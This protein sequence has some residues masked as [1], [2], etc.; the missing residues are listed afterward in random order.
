MAEKKKKKMEFRY[1]QL[2]P[3]SPI[4]ALLGEKWVQ[5]YGDRTADRLHFHNYMELGYCYYGAGDV[6][7][8]DDTYRF[9]GQQ[10]TVIPSNFPHT[11]NSDPGNIS[12]WEYLFV[13]VEVVLDGIFPDNALRKERALQRLYEKPWFLEE[14]EYPKEAAKIKEILNIMRKGDEFYLE[15]A[16]ALL[17][18]LLLEITRLNYTNKETRADAE[19]GQDHLHRLP[20]HGLYLRSLHGTNKGRT[21]GEVQPSERDTFPAC[22]YRIYAY[23]AA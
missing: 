6:V 23:G 8:G 17:G 3:G 22:V 14:A 19:Q 12:R 1:Y 16:K 20:R 15:E 18:C 9:S 4:L 7:L 10:F 13:D 5:N 2:P 11:T 21:T